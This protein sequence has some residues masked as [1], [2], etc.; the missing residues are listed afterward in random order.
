MK[1]SSAPTHLIIS[2]TMTQPAAIKAT[3]AA[4]A[5]AI[6]PK[7]ITSVRVA[8]QCQSPGT[9]SPTNPV[10]ALKTPFNEPNIFFR[11]VLEV[12]TYF[13][14]LPMVRSMYRNDFTMFFI[15]W[16]KSVLS[17]RQALSVAHGSLNSVNIPPK[18]PSM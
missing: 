14:L 2:G 15:P 18:N 9:M 10:K 17:A 3:F 6:T 11:A 16:E 13:A 7:V 8:G 5:A 1:P 4:M 12:K